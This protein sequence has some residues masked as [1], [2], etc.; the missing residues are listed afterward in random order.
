MKYD[1]VLFFS[2]A[3]TD[4]VTRYLSTMEAHVHMKLK[5]TEHRWPRCI[6]PSAF[7]VQ[8]KAVGMD[9]MCTRLDESFSSTLS[10]RLGFEVDDVNVSCG[11]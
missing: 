9:N 11:K 5:G 8:C 4:P 3:V 7:R 6:E 1:T 2:F 10:S